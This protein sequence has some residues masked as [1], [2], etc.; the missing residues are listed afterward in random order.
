MKNHSFLPISLF[1]MLIISASCSQQPKI[2]AK[3]Y[4]KFPVYSGND[5]GIT[6]AAESSKFRIW[7]PTAEKVKI[8]LYNVGLGGSPVM[9]K[10]MKKDAEGTWLLQIDGDLA[11]K[12]YTF[13][14]KTGGKWLNETPGIY[15][16][17]VGVNGMRAAVVNMSETNPD[18]WEN[19]RKPALANFGE[20]VIY[21]L[22][23]RDLSISPTSGITNKGKFLG[24]TETG[25]VCQ[26]GEKT[27][28]D[29]L[30]ELGITHLHILP[31]FDY[32]SL[33]E[34]RLDENKYNWGYDP[35]NYNVPEG[36]F[37][38]DPYNPE[39]RIRE[40][41]QMVLALHQK[42]IRVIMDVVYNHTSDTENSN[43]SLEVPGYYYR[44]NTDGTLS[45]ASACGNETASERPMMRKYMIESLKHWI[46][47]YHVDGFRFD[48]MGIHDITT[49]NQ[50]LEEIHQ[51][52]P[53]IFL[54]GEGWTA[55]SSPLPQ[56]E[57]AVKK[58]TARLNGIAAFSDDIR[59]G[60]KGSWSDHKAK[61]FVSG[62]PGMEESIKFGVVASTQ[63][64][65][66][67]YSKVN[68]S[69]E[70]WAKEPFQTI[71]YAS[72]HDNHTLWDKLNFTNPDDSEADH[73]KMD[74]LANTIVMTAQGVPFI[75]AAED[76]LRTK[77]G[78]EN[79]F[80]SPDSINQIDWERKSWYRGVFD[81]YQG[82]IKLRKAHPA[83]R[84][85]TADDIRKNLEFIETG[86][87]GVV[88]F[89]LKNNANG[90]KWKQILVV[91]NAS[92]KGEIVKFPFA[93]W[94]IVLNENGYNEAG[95]RAFKHNQLSVPA[96]SAVVL[97]EILP[98]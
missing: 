14:I 52:D 67:D 31:A 23:V 64:P 43:F 7:A 10:E 6:Y 25:T 89:I 49:M 13:R 21:E 37:S 62:A 56:N 50:I 93:K 46:A 22:H 55:G 28:I 73:I 4:D 68:Y 36:S 27:G 79:S 9:E 77:Q 40:F 35:Q 97:A 44:H 78:V 17:A 18:D 98:E 48:L 38:T 1:I 86:I 60:I 29:H 74:K 66:V 96:I 61:G 15:A 2:D 84:M 53:T 3:D 24:L 42:G 8:L 51:I 91:Y 87:P 90:D 72:C 41:K 34:T 71:N 88:A 19:D 5:L 32:K 69:K 75:H 81:Y 80:N 58:F 16:N 26:Q 83:F 12:F 47:E 33:D 76:F 30:E 59:D 45:N 70:P 57:Q 85:T 11:G 92:K 63:H 95:Y 65:Q 82:L 39:S 20:I 94:T 54:Y